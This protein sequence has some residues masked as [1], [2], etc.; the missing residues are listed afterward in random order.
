MP[1]KKIVSLIDFTGVSQLAL[2]HTAI[3]ARQSIC[4]VTLLHITDESKRKDEKELKNQIREFAA[5]LEEEGISFSIQIDYGSFFEVIA[6][7]IDRLDCDLVVIGTHGIKGVKQ[8]FVSSNIVKLMQL[9][10][11]P[12]L[13]I[14]G[15]S[16]TPFEGYLNLLIPLLELD[17]THILEKPVELFASLFNSKLHF[18]SFYVKDKE[19]SFT[20]TTNAQAE[21]FRTMGFQT[22][23]QM[24]ETSIYTSSYSRSIIQYA[25]IEEIEVL[26]LIF[27]ESTGVKNF[28]DIDM[29]NIL[30]NRL[31]KPVLCI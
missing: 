27:H 23:V 16:Q 8:T 13:I 5:H 9:I 30:L 10:T 3:I 15:H 28:D 29:E 17:E 18:L 21:R 4:L 24:E 1:V 19:Q 14:Q 25:D 12:A 20:T 26:V 31:G 2:E 7:S 11:T 22:Q 6:G